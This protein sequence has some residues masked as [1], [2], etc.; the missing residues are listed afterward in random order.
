MQ[1]MQADEKRPQEDKI[2][3]RKLN[4]VKELRKKKRLDQEGNKNGG[5]LTK[6]KKRKTLHKLT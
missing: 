4:C 5:A 3:R 6:K 2:K 1:T